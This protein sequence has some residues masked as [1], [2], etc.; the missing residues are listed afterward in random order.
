MAKEKMK[1]DSTNE[2][3]VENSQQLNSIGLINTRETWIK[4]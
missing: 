2:E 1:R 3:K 4:L